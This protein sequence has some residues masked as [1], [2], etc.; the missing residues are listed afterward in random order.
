MVRA[1][2]AN[3]ELSYSKVRA[4]VRVATSET[5]EILVEWARHAMAAQLGRIVALRRRVSR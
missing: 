1:A 4:I 3:G 2:F 5:E